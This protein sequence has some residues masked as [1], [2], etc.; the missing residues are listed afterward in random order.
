VKARQRK[1]LTRKDLAQFSS[2]EPEEKNDSA[3]NGDEQVYKMD[4]DDLL[5]YINQPKE[6]S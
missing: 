2:A 3:N 5:A 1:P 6:S 4:F